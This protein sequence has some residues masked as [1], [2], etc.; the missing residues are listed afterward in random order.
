[1]LAQLALA[2]RRNQSPGIAGDAAASKHAWLTRAAQRTDLQLLQLAL[3]AGPRVRCND[4]GPAQPARS[5]HTVLAW[6][7][8]KIML[9][10]FLAY[11]KSPP[12]SRGRCYM[13]NSVTSWEVGTLAARPWG[14][15][16]GRS[17]PFSDTGAPGCFLT[18]CAWC[19]LAWL[20]FGGGA[21]ARLRRPGIALKTAHP[22]TG[23]CPSAQWNPSAPSWRKGRSVYNPVVTVATSTPQTTTRASLE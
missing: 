5:R 9:R 6:F 10:L 3:G 4:R 7:T 14:P 13:R 1:M 8:T 18:T 2:R 17:G 20:R 21:L 19:E 11:L 23:R 15:C 12:P 16:G 22:A